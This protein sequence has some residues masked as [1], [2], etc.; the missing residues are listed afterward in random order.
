M[1]D[2]LVLAIGVTLFLMLL[3]AMTNS[4]KA[5][6]YLMALNLSLWLVFGAMKGEDKIGPAIWLGFIAF[7][8]WAGCLSVIFYYWGLFKG[9]LPSFTIGGMHPG[10]FVLF[11]LMWLLSFIPVTLCYALLFDKWI[12]P[13]ESWN[14]Y[15]EHLKKIRESREVGEYE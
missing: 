13:E 6:G 10:F 5:F 14:E 11:P 15:L 4:W 3:A 2:K 1:R 9:T 8:I 12:L 7:I